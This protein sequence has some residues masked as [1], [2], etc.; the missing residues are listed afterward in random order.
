MPQQFW[1]SAG[2][3]WKHGRCGV[4]RQ[5]H[6]QPPL[7]T[8]SWHSTWLIANYSYDWIM[9]L[10]AYWAHTGDAALVRTLG[11]EVARTVAWVIDDGKGELVMDTPRQ[12]AAWYGSDAW[13]AIWRYSA[14]QAAEEL[15]AVTDDAV[16]RDR[17]AQGTRRHGQV[18]H[19]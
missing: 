11:R 8:R 18:L 16:V 2:T 10:R 1:R 19:S 13:I 6:H 7:P 5:D 9:T 12:G 14:V 3:G 15:A 4:T 17:V